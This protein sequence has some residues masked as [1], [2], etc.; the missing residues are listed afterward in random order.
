MH[1]QDHRRVIFRLPQSSVEI[2]HRLLEDVGGCALDR[3]VDGG[4]LF[5]RCAAAVALRFD[6]RI[7]PPPPVERLG[8]AMFPDEGFG[9]IDVIF[10]P[11]HTR[12]ISLDEGCRFRLRQFAFARQ[13]EGAHAI[14]QAEIHA[15]GEVALFVSDRFR[16]NPV[17][18]RR[19]R[20]MNIQIA[21]EGGN[22]GFVLADMRHHA[23]LDLAVINRQQDVASR[24]HECSPHF[25]PLLG[26]NRYILQIGIIAAEATG[27]RARL[28]VTRVEAPAARINQRWQSVD[29]GALELGQFTVVDDHVHNWVRVLQR[30]QRRRVSR[31]AELGLLQAVG[32]QLKLLK[33][34]LVQL[35]GAADIELANAPGFGD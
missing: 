1:L 30:V 5:G 12:E 10:D 26:T 9:A 2:D 20:L 23:Q 11:R 24:R 28:I 21:V 16:F 22:Q 18:G 34:N 29:I 19:G 14:H 35:L 13:A 25:S 32:R 33:E 3:H 31:K 7:N 15:L 8:I 17:D 27:R 6:R 4:A